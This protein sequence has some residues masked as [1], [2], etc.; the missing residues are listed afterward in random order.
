MSSLRLDALSPFGRLAV[1]LDA[2]FTELTRLSRQIERLDM[3]SD[4][5]LERAVKFLTEF[6]ARSTAIA[7]TIPEF[8]KALQD[9]QRQS[10]A[11]A[12]LVADHA[13]RIKAR[14]EKQ[15]EIHEK[16]TQIKHEV[17]AVNDR[18]AGFRKPG[19]SEFSD[20]ERRQVEAVF[21]TVHAHLTRFIAQT[22]EIKDEAAEAKFKT[23]ARDA[24]SL[25][26]TLESSRRKVT[27]A[28]KTA[29]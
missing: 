7:G 18:L 25:I 8:S 5:D 29:R 11:A 9:A 10:E 28:L 14:K 3:E 1:S 27:Q 24:Q 15:Q 19:K 6:A 22:Q 21:E 23:L 12:A 20:E 26:D 17:K 16:L 4:G 2:D 13:Q